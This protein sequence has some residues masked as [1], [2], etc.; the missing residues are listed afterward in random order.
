MLPSSSLLCMV[1]SKIYEKYKEEE[2]EAGK[3]LGEILTERRRIGD[4][5]VPGGC[6]CMLTGRCTSLCP[7]V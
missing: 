5:K 7:N 2:S 4:L 1:Q 6:G 3:A